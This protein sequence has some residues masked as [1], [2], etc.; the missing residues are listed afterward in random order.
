MGPSSLQQEIAEVEKEVVSEESASPAVSITSSG[1]LLKALS[2]A[3]IIM[4]WRDLHVEFDEFKR[5]S[6]WLRGC[7]LHPARQANC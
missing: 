7:I 4:K 6:V 1:K 5:S 2:E 3:G